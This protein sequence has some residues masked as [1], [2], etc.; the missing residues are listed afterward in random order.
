MR[1]NVNKFFLFCL[2]AA[3]CLSA[4]ASSDEPTLPIESAPAAQAGK[5]ADESPAKPEGASVSTAPRPSSSTTSSSGSTVSKIAAVVNGEM[6]TMLE[7]QQRSAQEIAALGFTGSSQKDVDG[8]NAVMRK[9]LDAM[10]MDILVKEEANR[11][12]ITVS[13]QEVESEVQMVREHNK[14][15]PEEF[16]HQLSLQGMT[17]QS[18]KEK[19]KDNILRKR[20]VGMMI[21][22]KILVTKE[23]VSAYYNEHKAEFKPV[24]SVDMSIIVFHP[25]VNPEEVLARIKSGKMSFEEAAKKVSI[26]PNGPKGGAVGV[27]GWANMNPQWKTLL[28]GMKPGE[29]SPI[30]P[31]DR[32][33]A[34]VRL[35]NRVE[36]KQLTLEEATPQIEDI[37]RAPQLEAR[38][39]E[40]SHQLRGKA[41][42]DIRF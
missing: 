31:V 21:A 29:I 40:Y 27:V 28:A 23:E 41:V 2:C 3:F 17:L 16:E 14:L 11:L 6:I 33:K 1:Y 26:E 8:R 15:S 10:I 19:T 30:F 34:V 9:T 5:T 12:K 24:E 7:L 35:N 20:L 42:V 22:R 25:Q 37:L 39:T 38:F 13:D 36:G 32:F 18:Y 4:C